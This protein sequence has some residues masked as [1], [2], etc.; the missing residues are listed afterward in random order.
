MDSHVVLAVCAV[1]RY[2]NIG[3]LRFNFRGAGK[4]HGEYSGGDLET[5]DV[6]GAVARLMEHEYRAIGIVGY[7]FGAGVG[8]RT[9][10]SH[11]NVGVG[12]G[13]SP[14]EDALQSM[15]GLL[16]RAEETDDKAFLLIGGDSD[17]YC[18][19]GR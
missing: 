16:A 9:A 12:I 14:L 8:L 13:L 18:S 2:A 6:Y 4:S 11:P 15:H 5:L 10:C 7:S 19:P 17:P 3:Y 1:L